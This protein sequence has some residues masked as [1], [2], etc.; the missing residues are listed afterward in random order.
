HLYRHPRDQWASSL[1]DPRAV[2]RDLTP[3]EFGRYD[4]YYLRNWARDLKYCFGFLDEDAVAHPYQLFYY[5]WKLSYLFG[6]RYAHFSLAFEDLTAAPDRCMGDL[7]RDL[8]VRD[9]PVAELVRLVEQPRS[10]RWREYAPEA[11]FREQE[12]TCEQ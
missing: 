7:F 1:V 9:A 11:W 12:A 2:P 5:I 8:G 10:E 6:R 4:H 3:A